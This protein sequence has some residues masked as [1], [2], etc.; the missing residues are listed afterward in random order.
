MDDRLPPTGN[1]TLHFAPEAAIAAWLTSL[2]V[3]Y[4]SADIEPGA[5]MIEADLTSLS[6]GD[7]DRSLVYCSHVLEHIPDDRAA[8]SEMYRVLS[9]GGC[10]VVAVPIKGEVTDE[11]PTTTDE[12]RA[13]LFGQ[14]NHVRFYGLDIAERLRFVGFEV[15]TLTTAGLRKDFVASQGLSTDPHSQEVFLARRPA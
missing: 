15:E 9:P 13:R 14:A 11:T 8:M 10:A 2:S 7:G 12:E 4:L 3:D 6:I 5:A 1:R